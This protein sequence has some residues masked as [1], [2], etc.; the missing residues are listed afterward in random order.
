MLYNYQQELWEFNWV[1]CTQEAENGQICQSEEMK[2][3]GDG[4]LRSVSDSKDVYHWGSSTVCHI[5]AKQEYLGHTV[6]FKKKSISRTKKPL[7]CRKQERFAI[8]F[9][10]CSLSARVC[11]K[12]HSRHLYASLCVIFAPNSVDVAR[13][14]SFIWHIMPFGYK[15]PTNCGAHLA[16]SNFQTHSSTNNFS[17]L[18]PPNCNV[19]MAVSSEK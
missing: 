18:P 10:S 2:S 13:Y 6:N 1:L 19:P 8:I 11:L 17:M 4:G 3:L 12:I 5:L 15:S 16:E 14:A 7:Q 9:S